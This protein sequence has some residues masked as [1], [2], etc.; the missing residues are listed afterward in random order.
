MDYI[1]DAEYM[2]V[3]FLNSNG[4]NVELFS[5]EQFDLLVSK[6]YKNYYGYDMDEEYAIL[7]AIN[8]IAKEYRITVPV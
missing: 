1:K 7:H 6:V 3:Q 8:D 2:V 4:I 5:K